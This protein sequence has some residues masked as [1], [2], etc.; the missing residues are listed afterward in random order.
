MA[1]RERDSSVSMG[2]AAAS[3]GRVRRRT[4]M[5]HAVLSRFSGLWVCSVF[6]GLWGCLFGWEELF[7][8]LN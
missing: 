3:L 1:E 2:G 6:V 7:D 8:T 5:L 4:W